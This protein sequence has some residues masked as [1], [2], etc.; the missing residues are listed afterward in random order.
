MSATPLRTA[1]VGLGLAG[2]GHVARI[3]AEPADFTLVAGCDMSAEI[4]SVFAAEH[5]A[6]PLYGDFAEMLAREKPDALVIATSAPPRCVLTLRAVEAGVRGLYVE[7]PMAVSLGEARRMAEACEAKNVPLLVNHQR[8]TLP[9]F[10][11][12]R[13]LIASG[14]IG[15]LRSIRASCAGDLLS[16][17]THLIDSVRFLAGDAPAAWVAGTVT[18][19]AS[20][21][22]RLADPRFTGMRYGHAV[23]HGCVGIMAFEGGARAEV[24]TGALQLPGTK[25]QFYEISGSEGRLMRDGDQAPLLIQ[26]RAAGGW[27]EAAIEAADGEQP[28]RGLAHP[29]NYRDFARLIRGERFVH[30]L[31]AAS[32]LA[33]HE[34]LIGILESARVHERITFPVA[35]EAYPVD[36]MRAEVR[37]R[38]GSLPT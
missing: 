16:D 35:Q 8:R 25:Y 13:R 32:A 1:V 27:R 37:A 3:V 19:Q 29:E 21:P 30:P 33:D 4:R 24:H 2:K 26:D 7:K 11:A 6:V 34:I 10:R 20:G 14:A 38:T 15:S 5:P 22:E 18:L 23:E 36:L 17:G 12:M 28:P 31:A 9:V